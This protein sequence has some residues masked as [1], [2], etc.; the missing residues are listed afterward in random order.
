MPTA[1]QMGHHAPGAQAMGP[2]AAAGMP[3]AD[4]MGHHAP[5][6][7]AMMPTVPMAAMPTNQLPN[8]GQQQYPTAA[9]QTNCAVPANAGSSPTYQGPGAAPHP[10]P[11]TYAGSPYGG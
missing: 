8:A 2:G 3:T 9:M 1:D 5:G 4:P 6:A 10:A 11:P 7:Q